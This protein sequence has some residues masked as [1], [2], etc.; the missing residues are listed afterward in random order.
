MVDRALRQ[1]RGP[2]HAAAAV[3]TV[4]VA[5]MSAAAAYFSVRT[6]QA[7]AAEA[8]RQE[9][10]TAAKQE[11]VNLT[12]QNH[13]TIDRDLD[14]M[15]EGTTGDLRSDLDKQRARY[16]DTFVKNKLRA[17]GSA[18]DA[19]L[20]TM[21]DHSATVLVVI[22]QMVRSDAKGNDEL[23][24]PRH[25]RLELDMSRVDGRWLASGLRAAGLVS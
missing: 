15:I 10:L 13:T 22:D 17:E 8:Q 2:A 21:R 24:Q 23:A 9:V 18:V 19:G 7:H 6:G 14:H 11:A 1:R 12:S 16:R 4:F 25:Y 20:V 5:A 3:L